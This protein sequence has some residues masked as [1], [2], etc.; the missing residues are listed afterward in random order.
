[1]QHPR[2]DRARARAPPPP[3]PRTSTRRARGAR[4]RRRGAGRARRLARTVGGVVT[5]PARRSGSR[6]RRA[7]RRRRRSRRSRTTASSRTATPRRWSR[8]TAGS[9][10]CASPPS[11]PRACSARCSTARPA[12]SGSGRSGSTS[13]RRGPTS[14]A[15]TRSSP[16]GTRTSGWVVVRDALTMGPRRGEDT[17]TPHTRPPADIDADH[18]SCGRSSASRAASRWSS[19]ASRS[20]TTG[21]RPPSGRWSATIATPPTPAARHHP[22]AVHRPGDGDRGRPCARSPQAGRRRSGVT[23]RCPGRP[24]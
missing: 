3:T 12:I 2:S 1:M 19:S 13:P 5:V 6:S 15:P 14:R 16:P 18:R 7:R 22:A 24:T 11:I 4:Q 20:S 9:A 10:G 8:P 21:A 23:A 17:V